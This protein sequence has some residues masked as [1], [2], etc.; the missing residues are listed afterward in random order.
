MVRSGEEWRAWNVIRDILFEV[1]S[2][3]VITRRVSK[4]LI[5]SDLD[6][7]HIIFLSRPLQTQ[8][9]VL[10]HVLVQRQSL[11]ERTQWLVLFDVLSIIGHNALL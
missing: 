9:N 5:V 1:Q 4:S 3:C 8:D 6:L 2:A 11:F 10:V 7:G